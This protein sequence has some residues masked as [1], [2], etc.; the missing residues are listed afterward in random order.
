MSNQENIIYCKDVCTT[1]MFGSICDFADT[2]K[3]L[4]SR[5]KNIN[6]SENP[7]NI[8]ALLQRYPSTHLSIMDLLK[9]VSEKDATLHGFAVNDRYVDNYLNFYS[10]LFFSWYIPACS[11]ERAISI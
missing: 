1:S 10:K 6:L 8:L 2:R 11:V 5:V 9:I 4:D 3:S 7:I